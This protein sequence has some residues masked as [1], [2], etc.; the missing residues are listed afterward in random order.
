MDRNYNSVLIGNGLDIQVGGD[1]YLNKW[2]I[3]RLLAKAKMGKYNMLFQD[4]QD[5]KPLITG[6]E[7]IELF[8]NMI[9]IANKARKN[10]CKDLAETYGDKDLIDALK[11]FGQNYTCEIRSIEEIGMEDWLLILLLSLIKQE[12]ILDQ[13]ESIKQGFERMI[14]DAIYCKGSIQK[15]HCKMNKLSKIYFSNFDNIFTLN[16]DNT[17]EKLTNRT[18]FHLHGD[19][20]TKNHSEN[21]QNAYGYL[22]VQKGQNIWFP[23]QF[24]HCNCSAILDFSG[25]RK[26]NYATNMTKAFLE[27]EN[28]KEKVKKNE[29]ELKNILEKLPTEQRELVNIGIEKNL[30]C[31]Y[32][33]HFQDFEQMTGTLTIIGLAPQN[34]SHIF[35]CINKSN[36]NSVVFYHYFGA[37]NDDEIEAEIKTMS[38]PINKPYVIENVKVIWDE[39]GVFRP[40]KKNYGLSETQLKLLNALCPQKPIAINDI[41]WQLNS[42]PTFTRRAI[43]EMMTFEISKSKYHT[44]PKTGKEFFKRF[45]EFGKTLEVAAISPQSLYYIYITGLQSNNKVR[46]SKNKKRKRKK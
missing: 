6:D 10:E 24:K 38:L 18:V 20:K 21:P 9:E 43:L 32:N 12:D 11:D 19:F 26:Y 23:P 16:Y 37:K 17:I 1:D 28:L 22:R 34:D 44:T 41:L 5:R 45:I 8:S 14:F 25:N 36:I 4:S 39:I 15:L 33:Y 27:F 7:I 35:S 42:I 46:H 13:Y 29:V 2:I 40:N 31:G 30:Y 3:V